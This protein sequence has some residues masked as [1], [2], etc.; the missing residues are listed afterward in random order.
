MPAND[1][2]FTTDDV[3]F[4]E[5]MHVRAD[6]DDSPDELMPHHHRHRDRLLSPSVPVVDVHVC[7]TDPG[8]QDLD[9]DIVDSRSGYRHIFHPQPGLTSRL[10]QRSHRC[11]PSPL[12]CW[13]LEMLTR[14]PSEFALPSSLSRTISNK[15]QHRTL[16]RRSYAGWAPGAGSTWT[17]AEW[18]FECWSGANHESHPLWLSPVP[19]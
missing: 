18:H 4:R 19:R 16:T 13:Q 1:M 8:L 12:Y 11:H 3:S 10:H 5:V 14:Q 7:P 15:S 6:F 2:T 17:S 9:Q